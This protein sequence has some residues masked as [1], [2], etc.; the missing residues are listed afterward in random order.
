MSNYNLNSKKELALIMKGGGIKGL[1]YVGAL[2]Q[3]SE[4]YEFTR[5][6]GTS[7]GAIA[8]VLLGAGYSSDE[9]K[10]I[11]R[12]KEFKDFFDSPWYKIP[13]NLMFYKGMHSGNEFTDWLDT[14]LSKKLKIPNRVKLSD[15]PYR[16]TIYASR[17]NKRAL[18]F[19]PID[20]D[21]EAAY[22]ARCSMSIPFI[23][24]PQSDQG[25]RTYDGGLQHNFPVEELLREEPDCN[26]ISFFLGSETY[27][28]NKKKTV[29]SD[30]ISI[31]L[32]GGDR[33]VISDYKENTIIIDTR[34][35]S[36]LDFKLSEIEKDFLLAS[37]RLGASKHIQNSEHISSV[38]KDRDRLFD[39]VTELRKFRKKK[40]RKKRY[41]IF[42]LTLLLLVSLIIYIRPKPINQ[43]ENNLLESQGMNFEKFPEDLLK[44]M[45][46]GID[47]NT[48]TVEIDLR[49]RVDVLPDKR[50][51]VKASPSVQTYVLNG[52]RIND[53]KHYFVQ[54]FISQRKLLDIE[55]ISQHPY[56][57][58]FRVDEGQLGKGFRNVWTLLIDLEQ[59]SVDIPFELKYR[60]TRYNAYQAKDFNFV[61]HKVSQSIKNI[62]TTV[63]LP[64]GFALENTPKIEQKNNNIQ[65]SKWETCE[66]IYILEESIDGS[67]FT[68]SL[69]NP[70][71]G[72]LYKSIIDW[73]NKN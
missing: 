60:V 43:F 35:I 45:N 66:P 28:P 59:H 54:E 17:T 67:T 14:L 6:V 7:A 41:G 64:K 65:D 37:G 26:F 34:P 39:E 24:F 44:D 62:E 27:E 40:T 49:N 16:V 68:W 13:T 3:I 15:L 12:T 32:E 73:K 51:L 29:I 33:E 30:L 50:D 71:L 2:D 20:N 1:A 31:W 55:L 5:F 21:A 47:L 9:L 38:Q 22:A 42:L 11:L 58:W 52:V 10:D 57:V 18:K 61:G 8:A 63:L 36:T 70:K 56:S 53:D 25:I 48:K 19:D 72:Y 46:N 69:E 23:F 4:H